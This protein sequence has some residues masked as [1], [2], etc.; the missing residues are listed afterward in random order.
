[1]V[2]PYSN[3]AV[4]AVVCGF[5]VPLSVAAN[6]PMPLAGPVTTVGGGHAAVVNVASD[7]FVVPLALVAVARKWYGVLHASPVIAPP[8]IA[9]A[10]FPDPIACVDVVLP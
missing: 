7:P 6:A 10:A 9:T 1:M 3:R 2:N 5:A 8:P 4:V